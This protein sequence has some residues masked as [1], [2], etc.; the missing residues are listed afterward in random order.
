MRQQQRCWPRARLL[1]RNVTGSAGGARSEYRVHIS[2]GVWTSRRSGPAR[3]QR[4]AA[5]PA[6]PVRAGASRTADLM[7]ATDESEQSRASSG[8]LLDRQAFRK[9]RRP[10]GRSRSAD[11]SCRLRASLR[12]PRSSHS[13]ASTETAPFTRKQPS[14]RCRPASCFSSDPAVI[15]GAVDAHPLRTRHSGSIDDAFRASRKTPCW[16]CADGVAE[17]SSARCE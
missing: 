3:R 2:A 16:C 5:V 10:D 1:L 17:R 8:W 11:D 9:C 14:R 4:Q 6:L 12:L 15:A 7:P 13:P